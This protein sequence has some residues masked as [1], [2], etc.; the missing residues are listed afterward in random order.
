MVEY[1]ENL[2]TIFVRG[3]WLDMFFHTPVPSYASHTSRK[4]KCHAS[5][6]LPPSCFPSTLP[7]HSSWA[8]VILTYYHSASCNQ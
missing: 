4:S 2:S 7:L 5:P 3:V 8:S 6:F 1:M